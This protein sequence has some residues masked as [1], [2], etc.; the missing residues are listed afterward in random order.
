[1]IFFA[2]STVDRDVRN[3]SNIIHI[4]IEVTLLGFPYVGLRG[5]FLRSTASA[6]LDT[7]NHKVVED[8]HLK[9]S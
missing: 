7:S 6:K 9:K 5:T 3:N 2:L 1:M 8:L 4:T